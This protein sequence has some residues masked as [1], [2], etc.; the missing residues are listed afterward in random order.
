[1][2]AIPKP[3]WREGRGWYA[4]VHG[5]QVLLARGKENHA[6]AKRALFRLLAAEGRTPGADRLTV[7]EICD[8]FFDAIEGTLR[9]S[10]RAWYH[11]HLQSWIDFCGA[12]L[13][14]SVEP[15]H[16]TAWLKGRGAA[17]SPSTQRGAITAVKRAWAWALDEGHLERNPLARIKRPKMGRRKVVSAEDAARA[18]AAIRSSSFREFVV[19]LQETG[20]RPGELAGVTAAD[21]DAAASTLRVRGKTGERT[22]YLS[23]AALALVAG[24]AGRHPSGPLFRC[25]GGR[26]WTRNGWRCAFRRLRAKT[27]IAHLTAYAFRHLFATLAIERGVDSLLVA[28]LMG[29]SDSKMLMEHYHRA[30]ASTLRRAAEAATRSD[31]GS[32]SGPESAGP[33]PEPSS[34]TPSKRPRRR[35]R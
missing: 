23:S 25:R 14:A 12:S 10:T 24:L 3:W 21:V 19:G 26:A 15:K 28:E 17:W 8:L 34:K 11:G 29:H 7:A 2:A 33:A 30:R 4:Q 6:E 32:A 18:V 1:M 27:G 9:P 35:G 13:A 20:C 22:V 31:A 16:V 5:R